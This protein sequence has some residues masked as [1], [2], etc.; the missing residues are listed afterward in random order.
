M[1]PID[2]FSA[3]IIADFFSHAKKARRPI[4]II[5]NVTFFHKY[6]LLIQPL[7]LPGARFRKITV[8]I[9]GKRLILRN[10]AEE[11]KKG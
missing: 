8:Y 9:F 11:F 6:P 5:Q 10:F 3:T 4:Q 1:G 7:V 2:S